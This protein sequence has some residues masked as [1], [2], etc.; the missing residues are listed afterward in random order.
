MVKFIPFDWSY[1]CLFYPCMTFQ[2]WCW[3]IIR[4]LSMP[5]A[6]KEATRK[7]LHLED[8]ERTLESLKR[9]LKPQNKGHSSKSRRKAR[10]LKPQTKI[11][12]SLSKCASKSSGK[13]D[14]NVILKRRKVVKKTVVNKS[15]TSKKQP[16]LGGLKDKSTNVS[17]KAS[18]KADDRDVISQKSKR[19]RTKRKNNVELDEASRLQRR[20]R[21]LLIKVKLEQNL[22]DAYSTEGWKG[23]RY[24]FM[25]HCFSS[26]L[27]TCR[28]IFIYVLLYN[29]CCQMIMLVWGLVIFN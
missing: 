8:D 25:S 21:Y 11:L 5:G 13:D 27:P 2:F 20:T 4:V 10:E 16:S 9:E 23:Q 3:Y 6:A 19:R 22:I 14:G 28:C 26:K 15:K 29:P 17:S 12:S 24:N 7:T 18:G 1:S